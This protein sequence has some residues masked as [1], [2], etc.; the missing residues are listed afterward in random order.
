MKYIV[1]TVFVREGRHGKKKFQVK[2]L[3]IMLFYYMLYVIV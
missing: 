2:N 1:I 3:I